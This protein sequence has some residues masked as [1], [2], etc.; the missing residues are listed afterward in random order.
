MSA[1]VHYLPVRSV[2]RYDRQHVEAPFAPGKFLVYRRPL[3]N[4]PETAFRPPSGLLARVKVLQQSV[5]ST[6]P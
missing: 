5:T 3:R 6:V 1:E 4:Y 2:R